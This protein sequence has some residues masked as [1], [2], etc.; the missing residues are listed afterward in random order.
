MK[1][2]RK[3]QESTKWNVATMKKIL[4]LIKQISSQFDYSNKA[5]V[6]TDCAKIRFVFRLRAVCR[7][8]LHILQEITLNRTTKT[9]WISFKHL[10]ISIELAFPSSLPS[11]KN[12]FHSTSTNAAPFNRDLRSNCTRG[13][14]DCSWK[15]LYW[16]DIRKCSENFSKIKCKKDVTWKISNFFFFLNWYRWRWD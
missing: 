9:K 14:E 2:R 1:I 5:D 13:I 3:I 11:G 8:L 7:L 4:F 16:R 6:Y 15:I 10:S 12:R